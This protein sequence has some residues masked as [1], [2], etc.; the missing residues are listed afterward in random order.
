MRTVERLLVSARVELRQ[1]DPREPDARQC[2]RAYVAELNARA[3]RAFDPKASRQASAEPE[4]LIPPAGAFV[5]A[6]LGTEPVGCGGVKHKAGAPAEIKRMWLA[7][8]ARGLG[9]GRRMLHD[10]ERRAIEAGADVAHIE[11]NAA[12][13]EAIALY[14]AEGY[15][16]VAPFNDEPFADL[17]M[18]KRLG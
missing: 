2:L 18:S 13:V 3:D 14:R 6:Y 15:E 4:E 16:D 11:T 5:V 17:W 10:L 7:P 12:L 8:A 1:V 9:L